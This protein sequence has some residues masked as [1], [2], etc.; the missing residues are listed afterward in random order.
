MRVVA[1]LPGQLKVI[2]GTHRAAAIAA[3]R[4]HTAAIAAKSFGRRSLLATAIGLPTL[5]RPGRWKA[6]PSSQLLD[7][8]RFLPSNSLLD[9]FCGGG[10]VR[11]VGEISDPWGLSVEL[12][13]ASRKSAFHPVI[14]RPNQYRI[15]VFT[16]IYDTALIHQFW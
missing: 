8:T 3:G 13:T 9:H 16:V 6:A 5:P 1:G 7:V 14:A 12:V 4:S 2:D 10:S 15:L 11:L